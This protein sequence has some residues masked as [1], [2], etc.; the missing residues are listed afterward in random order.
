MPISYSTH[1]M[2]STKISHRMRSVGA[3]IYTTR[4]EATR[5]KRT[6]CK[7]PQP[8]VPREKVVKTTHMECISA[9]TQPS[10]DTTR[11]YCTSSR[12]RLT[13][14]PQRGH[15]MHGNGLA[16]AHAKLHK[17]PLVVSRTLETDH[18]FYHIIIIITVSHHA[19]DNNVPR[20]SGYLMCRTD[21]STTG[22]NCDFHM[23][24]EQT[25]ETPGR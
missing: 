2:S 4:W 16:L 17:T 9:S 10:A 5:R 7:P 24:E 19:N 23:R 14:A 18:G 25:P 12:G 13:A 15:E 6:S 8:A 1:L 21:G 20:M 11:I 22:G 3:L